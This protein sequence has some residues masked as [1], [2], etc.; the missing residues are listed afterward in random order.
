MTHIPGRLRTYLTGGTA[1]LGTP[2]AGALCCVGVIRNNHKGFKWTVARVGW[3]AAL[4]L[5]CAPGGLISGASVDSEDGIPYLAAAP[6]IV[7]RADCDLEDQADQGQ[8]AL[9]QTPLA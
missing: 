5:G 8:Q 3:V 1:M 6:A 7:F 9:E 2:S 4:N